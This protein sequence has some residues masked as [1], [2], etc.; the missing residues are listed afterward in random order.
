MVEQ[1]RTE[2]ARYTKAGTRG[3]DKVLKARENE[4]HGVSIAGGA[5]A[6]ATITAKEAL[7]RNQH[8]KHPFPQEETIE[9]SDGDSE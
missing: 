8:S 2:R 5:A 7:M 6:S 3:R 4:A 1:I 9:V